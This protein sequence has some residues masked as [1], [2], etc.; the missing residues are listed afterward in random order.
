[1]TARRSTAAPPANLSAGTARYPGSASNAPAAAEQAVPLPGQV[2][3]GD[4]GDAWRIWMW[5]CG[6]STSGNLV[7]IGVV[8]PWTMDGAE[9]C[10]FR[11][12]RHRSPDSLQVDPSNVKIVP[13]IMPHTHVVTRKMDGGEE[14]QVSS[15]VA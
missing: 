5:V 13:G 8:E 7:P 10:T 1:M 15:F 2:P 9:Y 12:W 4:M 6:V 14:R 11:V 3:V